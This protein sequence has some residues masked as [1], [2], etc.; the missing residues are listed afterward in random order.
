MV[1]VTRI[2]FSQMH[3]SLFMSIYLSQLLGV[4]FNLFPASTRSKVQR[5]LERERERERKEGRKN[6]IEKDI[7]QQ[8]LRGLSKPS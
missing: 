6:E 2:D 3:N 8:L 4:Q 5:E 1:G 7:P